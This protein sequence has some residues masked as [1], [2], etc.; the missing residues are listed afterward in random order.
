MDKIIPA[1][2]DEEIHLM[3]LDECERNLELEN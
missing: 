2:S 1:L 3:N